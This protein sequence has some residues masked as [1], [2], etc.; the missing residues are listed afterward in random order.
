M[1]IILDSFWVLHC[2]SPWNSDLHLLHT[3][4]KGHLPVGY[5]HELLLKLLHISFLLQPF[6]SSF[7]PEFFPIYIGHFVSSGTEHYFAYYTVKS[8]METDD[9]FVNSAHSLLVFAPPLSV[10]IDL[11][12]S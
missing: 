4:A 9:H 8:R 2:D 12:P 11:C 6:L 5:L 10:E 1:V 7:E 3:W